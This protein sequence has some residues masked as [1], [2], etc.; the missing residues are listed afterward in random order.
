[1]KNCI[2]KQMKELRKD[3]GLTQQQVADKLNISRVNYTR[4]ETDVVCPDFDTLIDIADF[5]NVSL[6]FLFNR[7][8]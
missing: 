8:I 2:G 5:F 3:M 1:M 7:R 4:Y 6:D